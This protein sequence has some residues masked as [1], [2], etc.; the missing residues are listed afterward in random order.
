MPEYDVTVTP[1]ITQKAYYDVTFNYDST[2]GTV[3]SSS[4][5]ITDN[6]I[7]HVMEGTIVD[8]TA[9]GIGDYN[10]AGWGISGATVTEGTV[11]NATIKIRVDSTTI[12]K[13]MFADSAFTVVGSDGNSLSAM[14]KVEE[15]VYV[16][17]TPIADGV[18]FTVKG[19]DNKYIRSTAG[20]ASSFWLTKDNYSDA[21]SSNV[22]SFEDNIVNPYYNNSGSPRYV[23]YD[24]NKNS[25]YLADDPS[26]RLT[27]SVYAKNGTIAK[28]GTQ[29]YGVTKVTS[30]VID[31]K[32]LENAGYTKYLAVEGSIVT[33]QTTVNE[34]Y[35][36]CR[37][38]CLC[39]LRKR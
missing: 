8:L 4:H 33:V 39:L 12:V 35:K 36:K 10:F 1:I 31:T 23:V 30:G 2:I 22:K 18:T 26:L 3:T 34:A 11:N 38:L 14:S 16:S 29:D 9:T 7:A 5:T 15:N 21:Y 19:S 24:A 25:V 17:S 28:N 27:Y 6:K 32:G 20:N 37:L 13:A